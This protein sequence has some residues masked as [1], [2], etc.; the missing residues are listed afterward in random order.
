M[1]NSASTT[2]TTD[3]RWFAEQI[4]RGY[5]STAKLNGEDVDWGAVSDDLNYAGVDADLAEDVM[6]QF[7]TVPSFGS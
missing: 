6:A 4:V 2:N 5:I 7:I 3:E 1:T